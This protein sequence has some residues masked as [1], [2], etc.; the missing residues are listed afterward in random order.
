MKKKPRADRPEVIDLLTKTARR[1]V[2]LMTEYAEDERRIIPLDVLPLE[3]E[4]DDHDESNVS[5]TGIMVV[6]SHMGAGWHSQT[7]N[8]ET[9]VAGI[10]GET[11][12]ERTPYTRWPERGEV[13]A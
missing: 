6:D 10:V 8:A 11:W 13:R 9:I 12:A 3:P 1:Y 5:V 4:R 7:I 2:D